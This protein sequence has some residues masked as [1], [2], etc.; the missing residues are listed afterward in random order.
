MGLGKTV[1]TVAFL[2]AIFGP[3]TKLKSDPVLICAPASLLVNWERELEMWGTLGNRNFTITRYVGSKRPK[4]LGSFKAQK[5][6]IL[7]T[8]YDTFRNDIKELNEV[9]WRCAIFDEVHKIKERKAKVTKA[10]MTL[11]TKR[12]F[13]L[14]G[15]VMQNN[16]E[17][18]FTLLNFVRPASLGTLKHFNEKYI[19]VIKVGQKRDATPLEIAR[20]EQSARS[21]NQ[22][23]KKS[24]LRRDVSIIKDLLP[25]KD[26]HIVFCTLT[27]IQLEMYKRVTASP[28]FQFVISMVT[29]CEC[30]SGK[31]RGNCCGRDTMVAGDVSWK[32]I[33]LPSI[34]NLI[35]IAQHPGLL[36]PH[37]NKD[38]VA[39]TNAIEF[40]KI[41]FGEE[42][43]NILK[44]IK[45]SK[46]E[47]LAGKMRTLVE[48]LKIWKESKSKVLLFSSST[49]M[50]DILQACLVKERYTYCR[51]DGT[52]D[53]A[54]RQAIIDTFNGASYEKKFVFLISTRAGGLGLNIT[55]AN[56]VVIYDA[57]W[58]VTHD[59][60]AQDRAHRIG[61]KK[62]CDVYR[63]ISTGTI[64]EMVYQR[65]IY[66]QQMANIGVAGKHERRY[67][68]G[69][70]GVKG[71]EGE[72]FGLV[73]LLK[74]STETVLSRDLVKMV[75][76]EEEK[77]RLE[78]G[79]RI[80]DTQK[81]ETS[82][83]WDQKD[84]PS[85]MDGNQIIDLDNLASQIR[86]EI[87]TEQSQIAT[88]L[89][90]TGVAY[91]HNNHHVVGKDSFMEKHRTKE[92]ERLNRLSLAYDNLK[93]AKQFAPV[94]DVD[95]P[96]TISQSTSSGFSAASF[97][98]SRPFPLRNVYDGPAIIN[99]PTLPP[100]PPK[101]IWGGI[102]SNVNFSSQ[103]R[104]QFI[105]LVSP[106]KQK[107]ENEKK[108]K[109]VEIN[110][111]TPDPKRQK[112]RP[113]HP[114]LEITDDGYALDLVSPSKPRPSTPRDA[115]ISKPRITSPVR[116][117]HREGSDFSTSDV[118]D[119]VMGEPEAEQEGE[120]G[121]EE[122]TATMSY[123]DIEIDDEASNRHIPQQDKSK[124]MIEEEL[125]NTDWVIE[126]DED[127]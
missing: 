96:G 29:P 37:T 64:E 57:S 123:D 114:A 119:Q 43:E 35:K 94:V 125:N 104:K 53:P 47:L 22:A 121:A 58:N 76:N 16:F 82:I 79:L 1:Q 14:T 101:S 61:Q 127:D 51:L 49:K 39:F 41:A 126:I 5:R 18:L 116:I 28:Q 107:D 90:R 93:L 24:V 31:Q 103:P 80:D 78:K 12:R 23:I 42:R 4:I 32:K 67:F 85:N 52:V 44:M 110:V 91:S 112:M 38:S 15:T 2:L 95:A 86:N 62:H 19:K 111:I 26:D 6:D 109:V 70:L 99:V 40:Q 102:V 21:L 74:L 73:N 60:Q 8:T 97:S 66:K 81:S 115:I 65:Q 46:N 50:L 122:D 45:D 20:S 120:D 75:E 34:T 100:P 36:I 55:S 27:P 105:D 11:K 87:R 118:E 25:G 3:K 108:R 13:G 69:V 113:G 10:A 71:E 106:N 54:G 117:T 56:I 30:A 124:K 59:L 92:A 17:E 33:V 68:N 89:K 72:I 7:L 84:E 88:V 63:F 9:P 48:L 98:M 83:L 77:F